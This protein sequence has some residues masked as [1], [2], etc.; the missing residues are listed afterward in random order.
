MKKC[1]SEIV[2][3]AYVVHSPVSSNKRIFVVRDVCYGIVIDISKL[4]QLLQ[5]S[6]KNSVII[7]LGVPIKLFSEAINTIEKFI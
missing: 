6:F 3:I 5:I 7:R 4:K 2:C 1:L